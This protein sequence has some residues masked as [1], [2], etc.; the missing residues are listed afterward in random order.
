MPESEL[1]ISS[2]LA[3]LASGLYVARF[4]SSSA[5]ETL[6]CIMLNSSP[7]GR[8]TIDFFP[9]EGVSRNTLIKTGDCI[10]L[11]VKGEQ[12]GLLITQFSTAAKP[13]PVELHLDRIDQVKPATKPG[14]AAGQ[15]P[16]KAADL[17]QPHTILSGHIERAGDV[18]VEHG[19]L[20]APDSTRRIEGFSIAVSELPEGITLAY[21]C[22]SGRNA[23]PSV[24]TAGQFVGTRRQARPITAVAF[25]LSGEG[26]TAFELVGQVVFAAS[27]P[28]TLTAGKELTGPN[29]TEQLVA[30]QLE[31]RPRVT[32]VTPPASPWNDPSRTHIFK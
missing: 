25:A 32:Q 20:G 9:G 17:P 1:H 12:A 10:V 14:E 22:R 11:R 21:S 3:V 7:V 24:G 19:W 23:E 15:V 13:L 26:A 5:D 6:N 16:S 28:L 29:G 2:R 30:L 4:G 31:I 8:G 27:P 18:T